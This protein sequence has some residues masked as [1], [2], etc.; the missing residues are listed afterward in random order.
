[1]TAVKTRTRTRTRTRTTAK[2]TARNNKAETTA[3]RERAA[4][5]Q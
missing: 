1:M 2:A 4:V 3:L 5:Q